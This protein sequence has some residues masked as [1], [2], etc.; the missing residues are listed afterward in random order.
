MRAE[1]R[2]GRG[3]TEAEL[4]AR[5]ARAETL[6]LNFA[7][8]E[9]DMTLERGWNQVESRAVVGHEPPGAPP[10]HGP[11]AR[12]K[13]AVQR[14]A[15]SDPRIV[16]GHLAP[17][18]PLEGRPM[19]LELRSLGLRFLCPVRIGA[20]RER[21]DAERTVFGY[22]FDT[23]GGHLEAGREWFLLTKDHRTGELRFQVRAAWRPGDFPNGWSRL[24]FQLLGRRYQRAWHHLAHVRLREL[25]RADLVARPGGAEGHARPHFAPSVLPVQFHARKGSARLLDGVEREVEQMRPDRRLHTVGLGVLAGMRSLAAPALR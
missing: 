25:L 7:A 2:F 22:R 5:L 11:F 1:W 12:L 8:R 23:L 15:F 18:R 14:F 6:P 19:L 9:E 13:E 16:R 17:S 4:A 3:W 20:V 10:P 24:G 21:T